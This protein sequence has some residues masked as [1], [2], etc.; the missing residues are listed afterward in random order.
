MIEDFGVVIMGLAIVYAGY[1][2]LGEYGK[3]FFENPRAVMTLEVFFDVAKLGGP[4]YLAMMCVFAGLM[5][6]VSGA[7]LFTVETLGLIF[8]TLKEHGA[9]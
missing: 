9:F 6:A 3:A 4:G 2:L 5:I 7:A 1:R 8:E